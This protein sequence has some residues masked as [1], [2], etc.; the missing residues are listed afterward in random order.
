M[1]TIWVKIA[2]EVLSFMV[3]I[4]P[5]PKWK[6]VLSE[7]YIENNIRIGEIKLEDAYL[8]GSGT[9]KIGTTLDCPFHYVVLKSEIDIRCNSNIE[10]E[11]VFLRKYINGAILGYIIWNRS[12][13]DLLSPPEEFYMPS[14]LNFTFSKNRVSVLYFRV[15][16]PPFVSLNQ[17]I[18][19]LLEGYMTLKSSLGPFRQK[20][21]GKVHID[22]TTKWVQ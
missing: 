2:F 18:Y 10:I 9:S 3:K 6:R 20:I 11:S 15:P 19:V 5:I 17:D 22:K 14:T 8:A 16:I 21:S 12:Q 1:E 13:G 7:H 4:L